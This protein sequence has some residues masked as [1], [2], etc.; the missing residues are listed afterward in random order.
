MFLLSFVREV[1]SRHMGCALAALGSWAAGRG[2]YK[3]AGFF[4][5]TLYVLPV[6]IMIDS[7]ETILC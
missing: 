6:E 3:H 4:G 2:K 1:L 5:T 7:Y